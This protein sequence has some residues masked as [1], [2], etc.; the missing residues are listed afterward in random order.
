MRVGRGEAIETLH[1]DLDDGAL[2]GQAVAMRVGRGEAIETSSCFPSGKR[3]VHCTVAMRVGRGEAIET[4]LLSPA[5]RSHETRRRNEGGPAGTESAG[6][7]R[8][9]PRPTLPDRPERPST[10]R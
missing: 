8:I 6:D 2:G 5:V 3:V 4:G 9:L 1:L 7:V 10:G